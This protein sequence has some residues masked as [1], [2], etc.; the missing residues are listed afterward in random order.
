MFFF[1]FP[2][3]LECSSVL[4]YELDKQ[5]LVWTRRSCF[6]ESSGFKNLLEIVDSFTKANVLLLTL[7]NFNILFL[8]L[9]NDANTCVFQFLFI[10]KVRPPKSLA[11][12][13]VLLNLGLHKNKNKRK[14]IYVCF[15]EI[16]LD[17][18]RKFK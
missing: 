13:D 4:V 15:G 18:Y 6:L 5:W 3:L 1:S 16:F 11:K 12:S 10:Q 2:S 8:R 17:F 7:L 14:S 9:K